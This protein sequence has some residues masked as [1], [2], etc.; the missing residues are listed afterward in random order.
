[1]KKK[2]WFALIIF[3]LVGQIAWVVENMYLNVFIYK[4]FNASATDVSNM[5]AASALTAALTTIFIG[6][7]SDKI[8]KR[9]LIM[10]GGYIAWGISILAFSLIRMDYLTPIAGSTAQA[11]ALG[12]TLVILADCVMTFFGSSANDAC[13]NAWVTDWG[14]ESNRGN[15]EGINAM[16]PL[17]SILVVFGS[18]MAFDLDKMESWNSIF[19]IIGLGVCLIG[20]LGFFIIE[21]KPIVRESNVSYW[22]SVSYSFT[23]KAVEEKPLL[24]L[25]IAAAAVFGVALQIFMPYLILYYEKTLGMTNYVLIFAPAIILASIVAVIFGKI[26]DM[27]G[28]QTAVVPTIWILI[29][30]MAILYFSTSTVP[31]FIGSLLFMIGNLCGG[32]SFGAMIRSNTPEDKTGQFQGIRIIGQVLIPGV[33]GPYI[34]SFILRDAEMIVNGDGTTS[35]LPNKWLFVGTIIVC[36]ILLYVL[37]RIFDFIRKGHYTLETESGKELGNTYDVW[38][39]YPRPQLKRDNWVSLN[40]EWLLNGKSIRV[41]F[42]PES[43]LSMYQDKVSEKLE[44]TKKFKVDKNEGKIILHFGAVDQVAEVYVN[45]QKV[46]THEGG[47]L[48]FEVDITDYVSYEKEN[49]LLVKAVDTLS[50]DYPYG[51]Q[52]KKRGGMWYTPISGIWK[53]VWL[54][55][56]PTTYIKNIKVTP[57]LEGIKLVVDVC[58][59]NSLPKDVVVILHN[60]EELKTSFTGNEAYIQIKTNDYEPRLWSHEDPYLYSF[61][62]TVGND[63]IESYFGLRQIEM[64]EINGVERLCLNG[65]PVFLHGVLDQGYFPDGIFLPAN[66]AEFE[67]DVLRMKELGFNMIRKHIKIEPECFY[68]YCDKHGMLVVQDHVNSGPYNFLKDT[69]LPTIGVTKKDTNVRVNEKRKTFFEKHLIDTQEHLYN[70]PSIVVYTIFNEGWGQYDSD[71]IYEL[72][73]ANDNTRVYDST[74]GWFKQQKSDFGNS[75]HIY[76]RNEELHPNKK[77]MFLSECGG[78]AYIVDEHYYSKYGNYG[79]GNCTNGNELMDSVASTYDIMVL[80]AIMEG[81]CGCVYTQLSDVEDETNGFYT[82]D[83]KVCKV[84]A[85]RMKEIRSRIDNAVNNL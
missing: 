68:Y 52:C 7:L 41:P 8:G 63:K 71:R 27:V 74:S 55:Y 26:Y 69:A 28:F 77:S 53:S 57:D 48:P 47:Y 72:A 21:D 16:M 12:V 33:I 78:Y 9:K 61:S 70:H 2:F 34:G 60:G 35:F 23:K 3:G 24:Y 45:N 49:S 15:I 10:S 46:I 54:E 17:I 11:A 83:R 65:T 22:E 37:N 44:Y 39:E 19:M 25:I 43:D 5:V 85:K 20:V 50:F 51:K 84:D 29:A 81:L 67:K 56:V 31:V 58:G 13:F 36:L 66:E 80:P 64:K 14:T 42:P 1:M 4:M 18:F 79:Y 59:D 82:Y 32:A 40:G 73:K 38:K 76:F 75:I 62:I 6:A 30:G